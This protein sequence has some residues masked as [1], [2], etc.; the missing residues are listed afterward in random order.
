M[1]GRESGKQRGGN[2]PNIPGSPLVGKGQMGGIEGRVRVTR[3]AEVQ[4]GRGQRGKTGRVSDEGWGG[5]GKVRRGEE[6]EKGGEGGR[7]EKEGEEKKKRTDF[8]K[9]AHDVQKRQARP[10]DRSSFQTETDTRPGTVPGLTEQRQNQTDNQTNK[11]P[12][13]RIHSWYT[14]LQKILLIMKGKKRRGYNKR[15][16]ARGPYRWWSN[17]RKENKTSRHLCI[18]VR[19]RSA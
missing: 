11:H 10:V 1:D 8:K 6:R 15:D 16:T 17:T 4:P 5:E 12:Y 9:R 18:R 14:F 7:T 19:H 3:R 13:K 2:I